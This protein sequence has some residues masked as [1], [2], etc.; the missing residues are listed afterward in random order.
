MEIEG[1]SG[2]FVPAPSAPGTAPDHRS[3]TFRPIKVV[4][5]ASDRIVIKSGVKEGEAV[6]ASGADK[7]KAELVL[8]NQ[9][10]ED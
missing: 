3:F 10:E 8:Q 6:V 9:V 2:V 4:R 5:E 1:K 7:L